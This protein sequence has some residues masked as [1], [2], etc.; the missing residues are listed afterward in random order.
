LS[1]NGASVSAVTFDRVESAIESNSSSVFLAFKSELK[2]IY[3]G[4]V[5][6]GDSIF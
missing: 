5:I 1:Y 4:I 2:L 3:S 6:S